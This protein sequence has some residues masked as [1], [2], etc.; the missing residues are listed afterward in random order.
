M[1]TAIAVAIIVYS[2]KSKLSE[3]EELNLASTPLQTVDSMYIV[4]TENGKIQMRVFAPI[5][6]RYNTDT[7]SYELFPEGIN[8]Y[9]YTD[10]EV[11]EST[12]RANEARHN[13]ANGST[14]EIWMAYGNVVIKNI[15]NQQTMETDTIYW[16]RKA[17]EIY[18]DCY[19]RMYSPSGF[20]QGYGMRSDER[21]RNAEL[22]VPF[23]NTFVVVQDT[24]EV[25]IDTVNFI[26]PMPGKR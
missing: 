26:G 25:I 19:I 11:L 8:V 14:E 18:T 5:M 10:D 9:A 12:I 6:E 4:Q 17:G 15:V 3:A 23:N 2:C 7:L 24:T 1:A 21:A 20:M 13:K 22:L 16:D